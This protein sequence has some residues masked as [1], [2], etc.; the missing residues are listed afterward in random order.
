MADKDVRFNL[1]AKDKTA[2]AFK[3]VQ[4]RLQQT[5]KAV[6]SIAKQTAKIGAAFAGTVSAAMIAMTKSSLESIDALA[7]TA[8]KIGAT[9]EALRGLQHAGEL[10]G[11]STD[12]MNM[13]LQRLTRR[14]AEAAKGTGEAVG[15]IEELG[16][17]AEK[18]NKLPVDAKMQAIADAMQGVESQSDRVRLAMKL[19]DSE[20]VAL[21]NTL[22]QG[23]DGL[24]KMAEEADHLGITLD[25]VDAAK[26]EAANDSISRTKG[27]FEG[28][29]NQLA[30]AF[31]PLITEVATNMYQSAL[32]TKEFGNIG[33]K[34]AKFLVKAFGKVGD[35]IAG[36]KVVLLGVQYLAQ[37]FYAAMVSGLSKLVRSFDPL[38]EK[39]NQIASLFGMGK[40][41]NKA[42]EFGEEVAEVLKNNAAQ[43]KAKIDEIL[44][45]PLPS[46][47]VMAWYDSVQLKARETAEIVAANAP[48]KVIAE[49]A[50]NIEDKS[51]KADPTNFVLEAKKKGEKNLTEFLKKSEVDRTKTMIDEGATRFGAMAQQSKKAFALQKGFQITQAIMNTY[52][53]ATK[54]L[55]EFPPPMNYVFAAM[56]V[57]NGL[58]QVAQIR[59]QSFDGGGFTGFGTRAGGLDG[60]GGY[61]AMV[62]P[63]ETIIDHTKGQGMAGPVTVNLSV[64]AND[65]DGFDSLLTKRRAL[66]TNMVS[67]AL[68]NRGRSLYA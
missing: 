4:G 41:E 48:G 3:G 44:N 64:Q 37:S 12:T 10:T 27:V 30:V 39:Y 55:A 26:I 23:G 62:H 11:V 33:T 21:V 24:R 15:A 32:D 42:A 56:T 31:S 43:T 52:A 18:L 57:A 51:A 53:G 58:A 20:G 1:T 68:A 2:L 22:G 7:K 46:E 61:M 17:D 29:S 66:I 63:N 40:I 5:K 28:L 50:E 60:K 9:T 25:R 54:A 59:A 8:D 38:I 14:V 34:V 16:L 49:S 13:A 19:F 6:G 45:A 36:I 35:A 65:T 47:N 67:D